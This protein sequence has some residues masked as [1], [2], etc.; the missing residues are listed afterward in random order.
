VFVVKQIERSNV[1]RARVFTR[2]LTYTKKK[3]KVSWKWS[4]RI[5][6]WERH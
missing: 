3:P 6:W 4:K 5:S 2:P 1:N